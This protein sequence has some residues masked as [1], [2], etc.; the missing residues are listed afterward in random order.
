MS[1]PKLLDELRRLEAQATKGP[2]TARVHPHEPDMILEAGEVI[3]GRVY[4]HKRSGMTL[5]Q[6]QHNA[7][8]ITTLR[9]LLPEIITALEE[10]ATLRATVE[11]LE[12]EKRDML[13]ATKDDSR[14]A[15]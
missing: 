15:E 1:Q 2:W 9:T 3:V 4:L 14:A 12:Q 10:V 7:D 8:F 13:T 11:R 6:R 5:E